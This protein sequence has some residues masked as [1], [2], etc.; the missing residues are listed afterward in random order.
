MLTLEMHYGRNTWS[1]SCQWL[2][3]L[4]YLS[5]AVMHFQIAPC[6]SLWLFQMEWHQSE[7]M[8]F[9]D[10]KRWKG[11][12][13]QKL[14][15]KG[16]NPLV[17]CNQ[18]RVINFV[19]G[20]QHFEVVDDV[21]STKK[22]HGLSRTVCVTKES[23][24]PQYGCSNRWMYI[25]E[26]CPISVDW[27]SKISCFYWRRCIWWVSNLND[28]SVPK[29]L[30]CTLKIFPERSKI[31]RIKLWFLFSLHPCITWQM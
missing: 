1:E 21:F 4:E 6:W 15:L 23:M 16:F 20:N 24:N 25:H 22:W 26:L 17:D 31:K 18:Q 10:A 29:K 14:S 5:L 11:Y 30:K 2:C 8:H 12:S 7:I 28:V 19:E 13:C 27:N 3:F 9:G